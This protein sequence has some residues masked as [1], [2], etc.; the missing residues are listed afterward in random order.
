VLDLHAAILDHFQAGR[1]RH[2]TSRRI[3]DPKLH[4]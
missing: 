2:A 3:F 1:L 4:P